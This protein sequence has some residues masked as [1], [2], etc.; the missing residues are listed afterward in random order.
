MKWIQ[1]LLFS[2]KLSIEERK[3]IYDAMD[4]YEKEV[5]KKTIEIV[6]LQAKKT[7][8]I[9]ELE[10]KLDEAM[11]KLDAVAQRSIIGIVT[12]FLF[13]CYW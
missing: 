13:Y 8:E 2:E 5:T 12:Y 9:V 4:Y 1:G 3:S 10:A 6:E 7:L 11:T